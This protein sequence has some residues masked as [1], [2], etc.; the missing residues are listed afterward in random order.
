VD[1]VY[2]PQQPSSLNP[3][4]NRKVQ[5]GSREEPAFQG[6]YASLCRQE[7]QGA[8]EQEVQEVVEHKKEAQHSLQHHTQQALHTE[9]DKL[10]GSTPQSGL[11][12]AWEVDAADVRGLV[13]SAEGEGEQGRGEALTGSERW[14]EADTLADIE[15]AFDEQVGATRWGGRTPQGGL[16]DTAL[17]LILRSGTFHKAV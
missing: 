10:F 15:S 12:H 3:E 6:H 11:D 7:Q 17:K 14:R 5:A 9:E 2:G 8:L 13:W 1:Y 16:Q 4:Q